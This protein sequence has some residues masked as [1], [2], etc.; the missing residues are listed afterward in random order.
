MLPLFLELYTFIYKFPGR[1]W[2]NGVHLYD[3]F[4]PLF[5]NPS[6]NPVSI[7]MSS[8]CSV[9]KEN[10]SSFASQHNDKDK[11]AVKSS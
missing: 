5:K 9:V 4:P 10:K 3:L 11:K 7:E 1:L 2:L 8:N 6:K